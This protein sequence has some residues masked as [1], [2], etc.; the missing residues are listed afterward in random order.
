MNSFVFRPI[1]EPYVECNDIQF[2]MR[3]GHFVTRYYHGI[4]RGFGISS[5]NLRNPSETPSGYLRE[6]IGKYSEPV[7]KASGYRR[8]GFGSCIYY[9]S[10]SGSGHSRGSEFNEIQKVVS[11]CVI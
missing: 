2:I 7:G 4:R 8:K 10:G 5:G 1:R 11:Q 3:R 6:V 9:R